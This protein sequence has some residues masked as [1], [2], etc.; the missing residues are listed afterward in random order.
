MRP[1]WVETGDEARLAIVPRPRGGDWLE[2]ELWAI[3]RAGVDVLVS[4]LTAEEQ[5]E[6]G[7]RMEDEL[8]ARVGLTFRSFPIQDRGT[9]ESSRDLGKLLD[10]LAGDVGAGRSVATHCRASIGRASVIL[11]ALLCERGWT[12][13]AAFKSIEEARGAA[14]PDTPEQAGW[15]E[16][17]AEFRKA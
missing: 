8:C 16:R 1:Y 7:L 14:V 10:E 12:P 17:F 4:L 6:L 5:E 2:E 15:V 9:P 13:E 3:K 11:A